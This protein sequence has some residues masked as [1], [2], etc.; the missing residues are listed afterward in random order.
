MKNFLNKY[1]EVYIL[2]IGG[3]GMSS[4]AKFLHQS[5]VNTK[6]Y[7]QRTSYV[8][9]LLSNDGLSIELDISNNIYNQNSLYIV[10]SAINIKNTF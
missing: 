2:G 5:G 8:T 6:G 1:K 4:I 3:S 7:D 10:S 9:D